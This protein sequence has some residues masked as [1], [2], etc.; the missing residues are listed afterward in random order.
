M[1]QY[2]T[3]RAVTAEKS[4]VPGQWRFWWRGWRWPKTATLTLVSLPYYNVRYHLQSCWLVQN[5]SSDTGQV[6]YLCML[7]LTNFVNEEMTINCSLYFSIIKNQVGILSQLSSEKWRVRFYY[8]QKFLL[9]F[10]VVISNIHLI[11]IATILSY[12]CSF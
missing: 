11:I 8:Q 1:L 3:V 5:K 10:P 6:R 4:K 9:G 2:L 7:K 12:Y